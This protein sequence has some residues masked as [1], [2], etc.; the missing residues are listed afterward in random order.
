MAFLDDAAGGCGPLFTTQECW[1]GADLRMGRE[2]RGDGAHGEDEDG[3]DGASFE[4]AH[5]AGFVEEQV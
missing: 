4:F 5:E 3:R 1:F 2:A